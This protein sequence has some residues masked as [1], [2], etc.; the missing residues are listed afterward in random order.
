MEE[1]FWHYPYLEYA[2]IQQAAKLALA[3][4][5]NTT[6]KTRWGE[7]KNRYPK[8]FAKWSDEEETLLMQEFQ[9]GQS[10]QA[11]SELLNRQ[12]GAIRIR[13]EKLGLLEADPTQ[14]RRYPM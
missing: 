1:L 9:T 4:L 3:T 13:L 6:A 5:N 12:P 7:I 14:K 2:D 10:I 11:C 8:A